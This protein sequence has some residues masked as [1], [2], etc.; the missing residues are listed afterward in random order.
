MSRLI[1][2]AAALVAGLAQIV[3]A[4]TGELEQGLTLR[5]FDVGR[6]MDRLA[7]LRPDQTP[8]I[9]RKIDTINFP[10]DA[11]FGGPADYFV[12]E[13]EG[14]LQIDK[15]GTYVFNLVSDDGSR[16]TIG[17]AVVV[18]DDGLHAPQAV[19]GQ[20]DLTAGLH[21]IHVR[22]FENDGGSALSLE[23]KT[24]GANVYKAIP[25]AAFRIEKGLTR[26]VNPGKKV[27]LDGRENLRPGDGMPVDGVH[28]M[29]TVETVRPEGLE[30]R[31]GG[32]DFL[33]DGTL[34]Y[35]SF[36][37]VNNGVF[38]EKPNGTLWALK[39]VAG[40]HGRAKG[41]PILLRDGFQDP[42]GVV[43]VG[44]DI[45]VSHRPGIERLRDLDGDGAYETRET[46]AKPWVGNN[47][48]HF[49]FGLVE[50]KD[51][52]G[53]WIYGTLSTSI[54]FGNT[55]DHDNVQGEVIGMNGPNPEHRGTC[56]RINIDTRETQFLAGGLRTP[57]GI[58]VD[59]KGR[60]LVADNQG[61][62]QPANR[63]DVIV[64]GRFYGHYN[65]LQSSDRYPDGGHRSLDMENGEWPP[66]VW[67]PQNDV[68]NSPTTPV[69]ITDGPFA[70]QYWL[71]E[72]TAGGIRR[73]FLEEV[74]GEL[75][76]AVFRHT[77]GL[78]CGVN[79]L[80][81]GPDGCLYMGGIG[82][83][84]NWNWRGT[85]FGLQRLRPT[86]Q[87]AFEMNTISA[88]PGGFVV[89]FTRSIDP[90]WLA[91][92][93]NYTVE[94]WNYFSTPDYG[95]PRRNEQ[96]LAVVKAQPSS[97]G[98][99]VTLTIPGLREGAVVHVRCQP[100]S[101]QG[102]S[103]WSGEAWYTLNQIPRRESNQ[104]DL[105]DLIVRP[106]ELGGLNAFRM[107]R[108]TWANVGDVVAMDDKLRARMG[109]DV[110]VNGAD[111]RTNDLETVFEHGDVHAIIEFMVPQGSN[112]GVYFQG[113]YEIQILD[114]YGKEN[115]A[116]S[117][118]GG[119]YQR[120]D[121]SRGE[122][123]EG[124]EGVPP[125][126][127]AAKPAGEWQ[128]LEVDFRAPRFDPVG[129]KIANAKF[130]RVEL[131]GQLIHE[132]I[133]VTGPT[134]GGFAGEVPFGPLRLQGDHG[135]VAYRNIILLTP[136]TPREPEWA[137][138]D[139]VRDL[140]VL[141]FSKTA[142]FRHDSIPEGI[143]CL[144]QLGR[145]AGFSVDAT[146]DAGAFTSE[147]LANY[148]VVVFL[149]TTGDV[150]DDDQQ[151]AF[152]A[153]Y[154]A[155]HGYLG[156]HSA[157]DTEYDWPWYG[158]LVGAYFNRHPAIQPARIIVDDREH[159]ATAHLG[160]FPH[161]NTWPR[162]DEWYDFRAAPVPAVHRLLSLDQYTYRG[163]E[164]DGEHP[165]AWFHE[166][167]GGRAIYTA[168]GH[169]KESYS[170]PEY[171]RHLLGALLWAGGLAE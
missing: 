126:V 139:K 143:A 6:P 88:A 77:Q 125:G 151:A 122:G 162:T 112:S 86:G 156:V 4:Q 96:R 37:P 103:I 22:M 84:G 1:A 21:P 159:P 114:S 24:P 67:L 27:V 9:D 46:F 161:F 165:I 20:I 49:A 71:G 65:G 169:T 141:V 163:G 147:N 40:G 109:Q 140:R 83:D 25:P 19:Q 160:G 167:D 75:Q 43:C 64:P 90:N 70:G 14:Y 106:I 39:G 36:M 158:Q 72:L 2:L 11:S 171:R 23:W 153:W 59:S 145:D 99:A 8:N 69:E 124:Y 26:V 111:G 42:C 48:H 68:S 47:Y 152:E 74:N 121:P 157:S 105:E 12:V 15:A 132:N 148:G 29:W 142:G 73:V 79:R 134:R 154:R 137:S 92:P 87:T 118:C 128:T 82:A 138:P 131:N 38:R 13:I 62:W 35:S 149:N 127:N 16:L 117:D 85:Q 98:N 41:P 89:T 168:G 30:T 51:A 10:D 31:V 136:R 155:G 5:I 95:G 34:V 18:D 55:L 119:V 76:G 116:F 58:L 123:N 80:V 130:E 135:P 102:E 166:F 44:T 110:I 50:H 97:G 107:P 115:P 57:N 56:W 81:K 52:D 60:I 45:Y 54:Y 113:R 170:E 32:M 120:W 33:P 61:A 3:P 28:P 144:K 108:G 129:H 17:D 66:A 133:E 7:P 150:L 146:E 164:M 78:E 104:V 101:E 93:A 91:D 63:L 94:Q 53:D 100:T